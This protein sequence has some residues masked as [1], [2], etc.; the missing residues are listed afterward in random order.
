MTFKVKTL[1][2]TTK[3]EGV[4]KDEKRPE[5]SYMKRCEEEEATAKEIGA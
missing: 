3:G 5:I 4:D 2:D 1:D